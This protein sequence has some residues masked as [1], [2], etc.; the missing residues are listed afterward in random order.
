MIKAATPPTTPPMMGAGLEWL[1]GWLVGVADGVLVDVVLVALVAS[2]ILVVSVLE[3]AA[4][5]VVDAVE[6]SDVVEDFEVVDVT[7]EVVE[8]SSSG[9]TP[10]V[11]GSL[12]QHPRK[13]PPA[14]QTY[15]CLFPVHVLAC[16]GAKTSMLR[17]RL[18]QMRRMILLNNSLAR[19]TKSAA[20]MLVKPCKASGSEDSL[21]VE[22]GNRPK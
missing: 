3:A 6:V 5:A 17:L 15:H 22:V 21:K 13:P 1:V 12:E 20:Q 16:R 10:V 8:L 9:Q 2:S 4:V 7:F 11:Q 19:R 14:V 18:N